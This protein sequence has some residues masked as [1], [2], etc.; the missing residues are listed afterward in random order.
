MNKRKKNDEPETETETETSDK[1]AT[2]PSVKRF[3]LKD[4]LLELVNLGNMADTHWTHEEYEEGAKLYQA[5]LNKYQSFCGGQVYATRIMASDTS[6]LLPF[7]LWMI[8]C[9]YL[10]S[11]I[12]CD[13]VLPQAS[14]NELYF[15]LGFYEQSIRDPPDIHT[16]VHYYS[17]NIYD[18]D[19]DDMEPEGPHALSLLNRAMCW[20]DLEQPSEALAD[21]NRYADIPRTE[22]PIEQDW[23]YLQAKGNTLAA[24]AFSGIKEFKAQAIQYLLKAMSK[25]PVAKEIKSC[26]DLI[27]RLKAI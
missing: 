6:I 25:S 11:E 9:S 22:Y 13:A 3:K 19:D 21:L 8:A 20:N 26:S 12:D 23:Y 18:D 15:R 10:M 1:Q 14:L 17:K 7:D 16:A 5:C 24:F 27:L 2:T 4:E